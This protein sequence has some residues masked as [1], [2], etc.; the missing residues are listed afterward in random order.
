MSAPFYHKFY[1]VILPPGI[2]G[3]KIMHFELTE[4]QLSIKKAVR[5]FCEKEF[6]PE[7]MLELDRKEEFPIELYKKAAKLGFISIRYP[8]EYGG[9]GYGLLEDCL[10]VEE[11]CRADPGLGHA[12]SAGTFATD[13][14]YHFGTEEQSEPI[15]PK[16]EDVVIQGG[17]LYHIL[18]Q[19]VGLGA[20]LHG[21]TL[22]LLPRM[23]IDALLDHIQKYKATTL[24]GVPALF[25]MILEN[26]RVDQYDLSSLKYV[27]T[28]G[29]VLPQEVADRFLKNL[30]SPYTKD[31]ELQ[32]LVA[33]SP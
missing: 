5:E 3:I 7:L 21:D 9:Q 4:E 11:L 29:D 25:R 10:V 31:M 12:I 30:V 24:F 22:V 32:R 23:N 18:G 14:I 33:A 27:F 2:G 6:K 26:D 19:A 1:I 15:I 13:I 8:E 20:I 28:G 17:A 16:G